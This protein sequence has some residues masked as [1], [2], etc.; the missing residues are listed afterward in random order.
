MTSIKTDEKLLDKLYDI[1]YNRRA[2]T[3]PD[4]SKPD[5]V[6]VV[7]DYGDKSQVFARYGSRWRL[8]N[9]SREDLRG[10]NLG[11]S[12]AIY[13]A[14][15]GFYGLKYINA[16]ERDRLFTLLHEN[17]NMQSRQFRIDSAKDLLLEAGYDVK[18]R[19]LQE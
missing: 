15:H 11:Y 5:M 17:D 12:S 2:K 18:K 9:N 16:R 7:E 8:L 13:L 3:L 10:C 14:L 6:T 1:V 4:T 19:T